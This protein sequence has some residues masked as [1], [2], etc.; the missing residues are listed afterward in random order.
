[1]PDNLKAGVLKADWH[2]PGLN[3]TYQDFATHYGTAILPARPRRP[4]DKAKVEVGV[5]VVERWILARLRNQRLIAPWWARGTLLTPLGAMPSGA[6][7]GAAVVLEAS[8]SFQT[9]LPMSMCYA[10]AMRAII[11]QTFA[12]VVSVVLAAWGLVDTPLN[13]WPVYALAGF[14]GALAWTAFWEWKRRGWGFTV[15]PSFPPGP[16]P[17]AGR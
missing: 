8:S 4:R 1:M 7:S 2:E 13:L 17:P 14:L 5:Q 16:T 9:A 3:P 6:P 11:G 15:R 10:P 12:A